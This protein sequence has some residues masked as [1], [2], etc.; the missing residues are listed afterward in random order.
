MRGETDRDRGPGVIVLTLVYRHAFHFSLSA[1]GAYCLSPDD[2]GTLVVGMGAGQDV[3]AFRLEKVLDE[4]CWVS[5]R[6]DSKKRCNWWPL[7]LPLKRQ[8][9][10]KAAKAVIFHAKRSM[11]SH[12]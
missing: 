9:A 4:K 12:Q 11:R 3:P 6:P 5:V 8:E 2:L 7:V 10:V 1:A